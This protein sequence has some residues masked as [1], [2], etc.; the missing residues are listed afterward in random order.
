MLSRR[1]LL[2]TLVAA[3]GATACGSQTSSV[4]GGPPAAS[5]LPTPVVPGGAATGAPPVAATSSTPST[6]TDHTLVV[7]FQRFA[8]DWINLLVPYGDPDYPTVRP[9]T[10]VTAPVVLDG[11]FGLN[12]GLASLK[13]IYDAGRLGFVT[14]TGWIPLEAR[15]RSHF[16]A[17]SI[18]ES[19]ARSGVNDGWL[20]RVMLRDSSDPENVFA[21][22]AAES[23]VP[24]SFQG[25]P[26]ALAVRDFAAYNHGSVMGD[27][28]TQ[29]IETLA[30]LAGAPGDGTRR[31]ASGM[32]ELRTTP[33][34][35]PSV[36]Y[37]ATTLG[38]G[39]KVAAQAIRGG[40][41]PRVVSVTSDDDWDTHV[42]QAS[43]HAASLP[44][45]AGAL[46][47]FHDDLGELL[48]NVTVVTMT[49]FG[50]KA[51]ENLN[52]TD[53]GTASSM[54]VMGGGVAGGKVYGQWPGLA[55]DRLFQGEDLEPTT[56]FRSVLGEVLAKRMGVSV[57]G[58]AEIFPG[59]YGAAEHWRG[60]LT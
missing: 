36:T 37:P 13:P 12:P 39:L 18:A 9:N 56:D 48:Q 40:F 58:L 34:P 24:N 47:A 43:R 25:Y 35:E 7:V 33:P 15:D 59:G 21:A 23:S 32:R 49:E 38:Q 46:V 41:A 42:N 52:G 4:T 2:S 1:A 5:P 19:G 51:K 50:R 11:F 29:L 10:Q 53:H 20:G 16:F 27:D 8:A 44:N 31:L 3:G 26:N 45:F 54:L 14:A 55:A 22:L 28:A 17:Q 6:A 57:A 30:T 60:W